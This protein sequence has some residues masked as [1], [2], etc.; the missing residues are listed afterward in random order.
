MIDLYGLRAL[1]ESTRAAITPPIRT[2]AVVIRKRVWASKRGLGTPTDTD[3]ALPSYVKVR[4]VTDREVA[5]SGGM[6]TLEDVIIGPITPEYPGGGYSVS[7][8]MPDVSNQLTEVVY[9]LSGAM[10]GE[11]RRIAA[12]TDRPFRYMLTVRRK[13][14]TPGP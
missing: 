8:I 13:N 11:Y 6:L 1:A 14:T 5:T 4:S 3:F 7:D 12:S 9:V 10:N 2:I